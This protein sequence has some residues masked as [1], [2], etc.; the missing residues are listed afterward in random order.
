[1]NTYLNLHIEYLTFNMREVL[2]KTNINQRINNRGCREQ[3]ASILLTLNYPS[4]KKRKEKNTY[5]KNNKF[6]CK[7]SN[8]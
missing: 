4:A 5:I 2:K 6:N 7:L 1:M 3:Y 8:N